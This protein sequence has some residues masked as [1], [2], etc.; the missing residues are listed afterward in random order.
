VAVDYNRGRCGRVKLFAVA[1]EKSETKVEDD[2]DNGEEVKVGAGGTTW[3]DWRWS[4]EE[5]SVKT[6]LNK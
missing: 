1:M 4:A 3:S 6:Q 2:D 5:L